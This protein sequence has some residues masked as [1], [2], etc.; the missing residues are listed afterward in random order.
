MASGAPRGWQPGGPIEPAK[1]DAGPSSPSSP[2]P[3]SAR[4]TPSPPE[5]AAPP[6]PKSGAKRKRTDKAEAAVSARSVVNLTPEQ[7]ERKRRNDREVRLS[8]PP[9]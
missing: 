2:P 3:A 6:L 5:T 7:L 8:T 9:P 1:S 4:P